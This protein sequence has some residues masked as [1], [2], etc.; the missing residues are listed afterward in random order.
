M[1]SP[2]AISD[3]T[4]RFF[5][6]VIQADAERLQGYLSSQHVAIRLDPP[7]PD[8]FT[9]QAILFTLLNL[10]VR[11][12]AYC[13]RITV[14]L[15]GVDRHP[16]LR[17][18]ATGNLQDGLHD[19]V[20][21]FPAAGRIA[22][23]TDAPPESVRADINVFITPRRI[24]DVLS[25]W[26]DGWVVYL[27]EDAPD[28]P[29]DANIVGACSAAALAAAEVFK[30][31]IE[32]LPFKPGF[33]VQ[34]IDRLHLS[35]FDYML[36]PDWNPPLPTAVDLD[37]VA[38]VGLGGIG[39]ALVAAA[40]SLPEIR[41]TLCL[42]DDDVL[43]ATTLNRHLV[44]RPGDSGPK[45]EVCRRAL[46]FYSGVQA[47]QEL[48]AAFVEATGNRH[49][50]VVVTVDDDRV[51][52]SIQATHPRLILNAG[53]SD[54]ASFQ[55][56]RHDYL[57]GACLSCIA[58][59]DLREHPA[60]QALARFLG[61]DLSTILAYQRS[62][63]PIPRPVLRQAGRLSEDGIVRYGDHT[64]SDIQQHRCAELAVGDPGGENAMSISFLSAL[65]GFLLL[66]ELVKERGYPNIERPPLNE[67]SNHLFLGMLGRPHPRLLRGY[68]KK[69]DGCDC[70]R[71]PY[72][73]AYQRKWKTVAQK[74]EKHC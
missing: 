59:D 56:T 30:R 69:R 39:S 72:M 12:D 32:E 47:R 27:N 25:V 48:Y 4:T 51:R 65:P 5:E 66:G 29:G 13:P 46:G 55:V 54:L 3:R 23:H 17:L 16:L 20:T 15:P 6:A 35:M 41:G 9:G 68:R 33:A 37:G 45:V 36:T 42:I 44:A 73:R 52:R 61:L 18:L 63:I 38:I 57:H 62:G 64:V 24:A 70:T 49:E 28:Q 43:D 8:G 21:P 14:I 1:H 71:A 67:E 53:A 22:W 34:Q 50:L 19:F 10:L 74:A 60:E 7:D 2:S 31:L 40:T 58:R 26:A 11:L